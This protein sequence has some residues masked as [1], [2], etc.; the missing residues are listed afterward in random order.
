[1]RLIL[2]LLLTLVW[3]EMEKKII[4]FYMRLFEADFFMGSLPGGALIRLLSCLQNGRLFFLYGDC[5]SHKAPT[6]ATLQICHKLFAN[7]KANKDKNVNTYK[8]RICLQIIIEI[9]QLNHRN[10][11]GFWYS[12][13]V[14]IARQMSAFCYLCKKWFNFSKTSLFHLSHDVLYYIFRQV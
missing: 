7:S 1:M 8:N 11:I 5:L 3:Q 9:T 4:I 14:A 13:C 12:F 10:Q 2:L 6:N